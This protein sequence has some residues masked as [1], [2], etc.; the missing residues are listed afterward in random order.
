IIRRSLRRLLGRHD[1]QH[2][3]P[4]VCAQS[5]RKKCALGFRHV[6]QR[7]RLPLPD[8]FQRVLPKGEII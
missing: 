8:G 4:G 1:E 7:D 6:I 5:A 2:L 3:P